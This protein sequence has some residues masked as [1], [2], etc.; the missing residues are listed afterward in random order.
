MLSPTMLLDFVNRAVLPMMLLAP[1]LTPLTTLLRAD[2][3]TEAPSELVGFVSPDAS[4]CEG[5]VFVLSIRDRLFAERGVTLKAPGEFLFGGVSSCAF[6]RGDA[7]G[8]L[9]ATP[10]ADRVGGVEVV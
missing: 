5:E 8:G 9:L 6:T 4:S 7:T 2:R 3:A 10:G 1:M